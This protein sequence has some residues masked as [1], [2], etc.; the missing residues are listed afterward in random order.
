M[1]ESH[2]YGLSPVSIIVNCSLSYNHQVQLYVGESRTG[3]CFNSVENSISSNSETLNSLRT[4]V[5]NDS[6]RFSIRKKIIWRIINLENSTLNAPTVVTPS[7][8]HFPA[9]Y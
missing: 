5:I 7:F 8:D 1:R 2:T 9:H 6:L 4:K 3:H